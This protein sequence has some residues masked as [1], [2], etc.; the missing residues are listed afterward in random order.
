MHTGDRDLLFQLIQLGLGY[1]RSQVLLT[2]NGL[3]I[4]NIL[5]GGEKTA[6]EIAQLCKSS[7][8]HTERLLNACVAIGLLKKA[9]NRFQNLRISEIFLVEG[10]PQYMGHWANLMADLYKPW[11]RL[12]Q[13]IRSGKPVEDPFEH[14][15]GKS[16]YTR[17]FIMAMHDYAAGPGREMANSLD[18]AGRRK[19]LDVGG[20]PGTHSVLLAQKN[21]QLEAVVLDL[22]AVVEIA[23]EVI[24]SYGLSDRVTTQAGDYMV[25]KFGG[26]YDVVL[27]SNML[28]QEDPE[29]CKMILRKAYDA[30]VKGGMLV[31]Q[32]MFLNS[33]RDGPVW[34]TLHS[35]LLLLVYQG[36]RAYSFDET[37]EMLPEVGFVE[38]EIKRFSLATAESVIIAK[39]S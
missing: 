9:N 21:P 38:P 34:P 18:L 32:A 11:G 37:I 15:G 4:F 14:L 7:A 35:L 28:H 31:I 27:L 25:D 24:S 3:G 17:N 12:P 39:K 13:A 22:P 26:G 16:D 6:T 10:K 23:R 33:E 8:D 2:A 5:S 19:L 30:L 36:G 1:W 20:G 29:T